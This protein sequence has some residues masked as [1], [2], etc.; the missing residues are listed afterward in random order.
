MAWDLNG[1]NQYA[2]F[3]MSAT[4]KAATGGPFTFGAVV[5]LDS[6][7]DGAL[8]H[9]LDGTSGRHFLEI[10][11]T[12]NWGTSAAAKSGP[13]GVGGGTTWVHIIMSK[14]TGTVP[15]EY[16]IFDLTAATAPTSGTATGGNLSNGAAPG[17]AGVIQAGRFDGSGTEYVDGKVEALWAH[18]S[19]MD[20]AAREALTT[21]SATVTAA[22]VSTAGWAV[23]LDTLSTINDAT[24]AGGNETGRFGTSPFTLAAGP[25]GSF[26]GGGS[27]VN[28]VL[29]AS[30]PAPTAA[31][32]ATPRHPAALAAT[33][34]APAATIVAVP[35]HPAVLAATLPAPAA[36]LVAKPRVLAVLAATLPAPTSVAI[37]TPR[38][39]A[40][41]AAVLPAPTATAQARPRVNAVAVATLPAPVATMLAAP[42][43][44]V[45]L[46]AVL[47]APAA[48]AIATVRH[49]AQLV[50][51]L[52]AP[53]ATIVKDVTPYR[54]A[55]LTPG[56]A[57]PVT[58]TAGAGARATLT[59]G[60]A[61]TATLTSSTL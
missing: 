6:A 42:T 49:G 41:L 18:A 44:L 11:T 28:A 27:T 33:L 43:R 46:S 25:S 30:L 29:A 60:A 39:P 9:F 5:N 37:A 4:L 24:P 21:W 2:Q 7:T 45:L 1:S 53:V 14:P 19:Y 16:T 36:A 20:A 54:T 3:T 26:F 50:A 61:Q 10:F 59:P 48:T 40:V 23:R 51:T 32:V 12:Y 34:P 52:P 38:H 57:T 22:S 58:L 55:V 56:A 13:A 8:I 35:R 17:A 15:V 47:P 31:A